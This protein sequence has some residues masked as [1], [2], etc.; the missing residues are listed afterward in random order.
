MLNETASGTTWAGLA[1]TASKCI[2]TF[3]LSYRLWST[4]KFPELMQPGMWHPQQASAAEVISDR[5]QHAYN[6]A[7]TCTALS[8]TAL[9]STQVVALLNERYK[10]GDE[11]KRSIRD[12]IL[13]LI[14]AKTY[15]CGTAWHW[16]SAAMHSTTE[17]C[18]VITPLLWRS[19]LHLLKAASSTQCYSGTN[20]RFT[21]S[22]VAA[23]FPVN[24][25]DPPHF[26]C[27]HTQYST[28]QHST[29]CVA[30]WHA[31]KQWCA[32]LL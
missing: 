22:I 10:V 12:D 3:P 5:C 28:A 9:V 1:G 8:R 11:L 2:I 20:A 13:R 4:T 14:E 23:A 18:T 29:A 6:C 21:D 25:Q 27:Q 32:V 24:S 30:K 17:S 15:R 26:P 16:H 19:I 31:T 7:V